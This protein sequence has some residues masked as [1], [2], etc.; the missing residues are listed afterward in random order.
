[1][2]TRPPLQIDL[3]RSPVSPPPSHVQYTMVGDL[4]SHEHRGVIPRAFEDLFSTLAALHEREGWDWD[5]KV[6]E[7]TTRGRA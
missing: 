4:S 5:V 1:M 6:G 3:Y 7:R 2:L